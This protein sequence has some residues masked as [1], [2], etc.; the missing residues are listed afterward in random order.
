VNRVI[1]EM[2][3]DGRA[4]RTEL[5]RWEVELREWDAAA[6]KRAAAHGRE[7][8]ALRSDVK[9]GFYAIDA[10]IQRDERSTEEI[11]AELRAARARD[12]EE[13]DEMRAQREGL[14][15]ILDELRG[16]GGPSPEGT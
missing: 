6:R 9:R 5:E 14:L 1:E 7:L 2:R 10:G 11:I 15:R 12:R 3:A 16:E 8:R 4:T 13:R